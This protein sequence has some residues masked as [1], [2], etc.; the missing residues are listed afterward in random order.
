ML[1]YPESAGSS[2]RVMKAMRL[3]MAALVPVLGS[4]RGHAGVE[5]YAVEVVSPRDSL[6]AAMTEGVLAV[7]IR[8]ATGI[9]RIDL[10]LREED[11][12]WPEAVVVSIQT[13]DGKPLKELEGFTVSG[14]TMR[15]E[16]SRRTSGSME[17][18][19]VA[20]DAPAGPGKKAR[21]VK[22]VV[23]KTEEAM[24]V[25]IPGTLLKGE[26]KVRIQWIDFYR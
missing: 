3:M 20:P 1:R 14:K 7:R 15:I 6:R 24:T 22:V 19:E 25:T 23:E 4:V 12:D 11:G 17:C 5:D 9:G 2:A 18:V 16:G 8:S 10:G 13:E 21:R 26:R